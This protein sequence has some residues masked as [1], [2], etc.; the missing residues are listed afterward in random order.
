MKIVPPEWSQ[1]DI[2]E[3]LSELAD[4][5]RVDQDG[6]PVNK[7]YALLMSMSIRKMSIMAQEDQH[8]RLL[9]NQ[10]DLERALIN[11]GRRRELGEL[12]SQGLGLEVYLKQSKNTEHGPE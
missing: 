1:G 3:C 12:C 4:F 8:G 6:K 9:S 7:L 11:Q 2:R 5:C 10:R